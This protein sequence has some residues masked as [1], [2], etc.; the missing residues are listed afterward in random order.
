MRFFDTSPCLPSAAMPARQQA[1]EALPAELVGLRRP[2]ACRVA[3][4]VR[5][6][7]ALTFDIGCSIGISIYRH[8]SPLSLHCYCLHSYELSHARTAGSTLAMASVGRLVVLCILLNTATIVHALSISP[9]FADVRGG[10]TVELTASNG[11][12]SPVHAEVRC[13]FGTVQVSAM[14]LNDFMHVRV[15]PFETKPL[16]TLSS[17]SRSGCGCHAARQ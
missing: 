16:I 1:S 3:V 13:V 17:C 15:A 8:V 10:A 5:A 14:T 9:Y 6:A 11:F 12:R 4:V 7:H 2:C